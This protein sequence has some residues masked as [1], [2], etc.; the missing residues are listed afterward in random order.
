M[1]K[2]F[3]NLFLAFAVGLV[4]GS[5][6]FVFT[7][8]YQKNEILKQA[9][10]NRLSEPAIAGVSDV[11]FQ[12]INPQSVS[13]TA[14]V[15][16]SSSA[17]V[18][19]SSVDESDFGTVTGK[20]AYPTPDNKFEMVVCGYNLDNDKIV[21]SEGIRNLTYSFKLPSGNYFIYARTN[22]SNS[23]K[24]KAYYNVLECRTGPGC[25][26]KPKPATVVVKPNKII[27][28]VNPV[29]WYEGI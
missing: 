2:N 22:E 28:A 17:I 6:Y 24:G 5:S 23:F 8:W 29:D 10:I 27:E 3:F 26:S 7:D 19:V 18:S 20:L 25:P 13:P 15:Q 16:S 4:S 14:F 1:F 11:N 9:V 21:C 12:A